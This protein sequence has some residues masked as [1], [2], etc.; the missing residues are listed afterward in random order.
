MNISANSNSLQSN[1]TF[2]NTTAKNI[3]QPKAELTKEIPNLI[4]AQAVNA[5]NVSAIKTQ[6]QMIGSL[7]DVKA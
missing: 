1:Q 6:D 3:S 5:V 7:L 2:L 4:V